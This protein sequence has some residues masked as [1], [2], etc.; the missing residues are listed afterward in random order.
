[1]ASDLLGAFFRWWSLPFVLTTVV[2]GALTAGD[3]GGSALFALVC[4]AWWT[5]TRWRMLSAHL[6]SCAIK[7]SDMP[8]VWDGTWWFILLSVPW[9]VVLATHKSL[10]TAKERDAAARE[11]EAA[12]RAMCHILYGGASLLKIN[13]DFMDVEYSC[14]PIFGASLIAR[15]PSEWGVD[16]WALS[17]WLTRA[18]PLLT[19]VIELAVPVL[20]VLVGPATGVATGLA[21]HAGIAVTPSPNNAGS[22]SVTAALWYFSLLP[23][24]IGGAL[25]ELFEPLDSRLAT[26][27]KPPLWGGVALAAAAASYASGFTTC[28]AAGF[29][30]VVQC[31]VCARA[32]DLHRRSA[33]AP[34]AA[35]PAAP[36]RALA[37][38]V[39]VVITTWCV[40]NMIERVTCLLPAA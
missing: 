25:S 6:L 17:V 3:V 37:W 1:M 10:A 26:G 35:R 33:A 19:V 12:M 40:L 16:D 8:C 7:L 27:A 32:F 5:P 11:L 14:A 38:R 39:G 30:F 22:F 24:A 23:D 15:L 21:L 28:G 36:P 34:A 18:F 29:A 20:S 31:C 9:I 13:R 2:T 4:A